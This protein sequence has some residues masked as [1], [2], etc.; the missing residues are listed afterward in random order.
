L[1]E[2]REALNADQTQVFQQK[3]A[4]ELRVQDL[5][6][7]LS[8]EITVQTTL[9]EDL[10]KVKAAIATKT[11]Q[12]D[13]ITPRFRELQARENELDTRIK[14]LNSKRNELYSKQGAG[15]RFKTKEER[16]KHIEKELRALERQI[17]QEV[18]SQERL[19]REIQAEAVEYDNLRE[20]LAHFTQDYEKQREEMDSK[21]EERLRLSKSRE[22]RVMRRK[23]LWRE[24]QNVQA[25]AAQLD[26]DYRQAE[27]N[28]AHSAGKVRFT[29]LMVL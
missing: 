14:I 22:E 7:E 5:A 19:E 26:E 11:Q 28:L 12:R 16:D 1:K 8:S 21:Q 6:A 9:N 27:N 10:A 15:D 20:L 4:V 25:Q 17:R 24:E 29:T 2:D 3:T 18:D 13:A 23:E